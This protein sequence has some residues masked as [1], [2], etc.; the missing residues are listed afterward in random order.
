[1]LKELDTRV[2]EIAGKWD[3]A[4]MP[5]KKTATSFVG[6]SNLCIF[7]DSKNKQ[8]A[9]EFIE[10]MSR[11][12]IQIQWYKLTTDLPTRLEAW[13]NDYFA[14][15]ENSFLIAEQRHFFP[16]NSPAEFGKTIIEAL[17]QG[18]VSYMQLQKEVRS[19][20]SSPRSGKGT[21]SVR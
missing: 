4:V 8:A 2:P 6:G 17:I 15:K 18:P 9:W 20:L 11:P 14:D 13:E 10:F 21:L 7:K 3:V 19:R 16:S 5:M 1:M 12:D